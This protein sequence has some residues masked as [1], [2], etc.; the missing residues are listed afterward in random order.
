MSAGRL[1]NSLGDFEANL[2]LFLPSLLACMVMVH[3]SVK[4]NESST[5]SQAFKFH[6]TTPIFYSSAA[7]F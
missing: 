6:L 3:A 2:P 1:R 4:P 5:S 7:S